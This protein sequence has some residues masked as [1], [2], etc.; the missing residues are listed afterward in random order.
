MGPS[1]FEV[2]FD[3][4]EPMVQADT[5]VMFRTMVK[6]LCARKGL[7]ASFMAKPRLENISA[8]GWH[9]HQ[10]VVDADGTNLFMP[11]DSGAMSD[12]ASAWVAGLLDHANA[13]SVLVSPTVNS[14][15]R[16]QPFQLAPNRIGWG[17]DNRGAMLRALMSPGDGA[18]RVENRAPDS[19]ANPYYAFAS[20]ILA[21][22]DGVMRDL[23]PPLPTV[24]PYD[25]GMQALPGSLAEAIDAFSG[26]TMFRT[27]LGD[28]FVDYLCRLKRHEWQRY[29]SAISEWE[30]AEYFSL[31]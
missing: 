22:L 10:S 30:Q 8:N 9:I 15:K 23:K 13:A 4:A 1:Q 7:H 21:G 24:S 2:T 11:N 28:E 17:E 3:P 6:E 16:Y 31:Y 18:S 5:M 29:I 12:I 20:Q 19:T 25:E 27:A 14:Y 26:S